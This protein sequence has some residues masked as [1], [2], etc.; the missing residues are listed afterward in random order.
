MDDVYGSLVIGLEVILFVDEKFYVGF[1][2]DDE[3]FV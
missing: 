1:N 3:L 2:L